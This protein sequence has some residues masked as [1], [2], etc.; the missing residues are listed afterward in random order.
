[1]GFSSERVKLME[2]CADLLTLVLLGLYTVSNMF[3]INRDITKFDKILVD[4]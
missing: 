3:Y 1:M 4:A 2:M